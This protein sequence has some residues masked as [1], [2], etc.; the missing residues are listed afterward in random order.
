MS[1]FT[2]SRGTRGQHVAP[3]YQSAPYRQ[4]PSTRQHIY[5]RIQP[6]DSPSRDWRWLVYGS[7]AALLL[8]WVA[9]R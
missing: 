7:I 3:M 1:T 4:H 5:G 2:T 9:A 6:M 8:M